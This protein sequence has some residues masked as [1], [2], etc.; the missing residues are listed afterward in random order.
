M[1]NIKITNK[2]KK[3]QLG[4]KFIIGFHILNIIIW[5][6]GQGGA[7]IAYDTVAQWGL[8][9]ARE[10]VDPFCI[11][12]NKAIGLADV[13][14]APPIFII[15][16]IGLWK[17]RF[18]GLMTSYMCFGIGFYWTAIAWVKQIFL[19]Q[20][21]VKCEPF[22]VGIHGMLGFVFLF[23]IWGS[24]YLYKNRLQFD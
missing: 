5:I 15:A 3:M 13:I 7:V 23:S 8:Q 1:R 10:T 14:I 24:W 17:M 12:I 20:A 18:Y 11:V 2:P 9:E 6:V 16:T 21:G 22:D 4:I 19:T